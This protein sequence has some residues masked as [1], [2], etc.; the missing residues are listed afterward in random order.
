M[1]AVQVDAS[2]DQDLETVDQSV[3]LPVSVELQQIQNC[4]KIV[5]L[6]SFFNRCKI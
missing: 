1:N 2:F 3:T 6:I 5:E 4:V